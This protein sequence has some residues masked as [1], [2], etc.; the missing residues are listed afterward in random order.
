[1]QIFRSIGKRLSVRNNLKLVVLHVWR[2]F[3][4][5]NYVIIQCI[6]ILS[7]FHFIF[8]CKQCKMFINPAAHLLI[9][10][11]YMQRVSVFDKSKNHNSTKNNYQKNIMLYCAW[12]WQVDKYN[13]SFILAGSWQLFKWEPL[14]LF[15]FCFHGLSAD[16]MENH[17][18]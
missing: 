4:Y 14:M 5:D 15:R 3:C 18:I 17:L 9:K 7:I 8:T 13:I 1:M 2:M 6:Y 10:F 12:F 11:A 16:A